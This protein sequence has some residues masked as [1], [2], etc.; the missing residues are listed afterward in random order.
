M[1]LMLYWFNHYQL[2]GVSNEEVLSICSYE[3]FLFQQFLSRF[4]WNK[5]ERKKK[6]KKKKNH[7]T[8]QVIQIVLSV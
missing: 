1:S 4:L 8:I 6:K 3:S 2:S 5:D 7:Q